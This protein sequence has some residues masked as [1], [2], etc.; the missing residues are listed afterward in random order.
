[1]NLE[2]IP[3]GYTPFSFGLENALKKAN[4]NTHPKQFVIAGIKNVLDMWIGVLAIVM[5]MG[6]LALIISEYTSVFQMLGAP[7]IPLLNLLQVPEAA[8]ASQTLV[9]GFADM[10]LPSVM[11][12]NIASDMTRFIIAAVSVTQLIYMSEVGGLLL[13]SKIPINIKDLIILFIERTLVTLPVIV[14]LANL[15]F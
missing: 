8:A 9:I 12:V 2:V 5:A 3:E 1:K 13:G 14:L 6:G 7:F 15:I 11:A 10:F 4:S